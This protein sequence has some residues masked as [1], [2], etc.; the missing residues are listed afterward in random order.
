M[1]R[2]AGLGVFGLLAVIVAGCGGGPKLVPVNGRVI[3]AD[4]RPVTAASVSFTPDA[5][6]GDSG[7]LATGLLAEDGTFI[8]RTYPH[9]DGAMV[10]SYRVTVSL[11]FGATPK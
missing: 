7:I 1:H 8:L 2:I 10:G 11:G 3:Y 5:A 9:G 6:K 4:G